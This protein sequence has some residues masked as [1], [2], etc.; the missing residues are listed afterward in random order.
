MVVADFFSYRVLG[1]IK[2]PGECWIGQLKGHKLLSQIKAVDSN[3]RNGIYS[4]SK[5]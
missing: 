3:N 5:H 2:I 4:Y 1:R